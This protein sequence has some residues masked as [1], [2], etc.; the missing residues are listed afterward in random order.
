[1]IGLPFTLVVDGQSIVDALKPYFER[2]IMDNAEI[3]TALNTANA[4]LEA[5]NTKLDL[6]VEHFDKGINEVIVAISN[7]TNVPQE[8]VDAVNRLQ[9]NVAAASA[10]VDI[11]EG[12]AQTLD[13]LNVDTPPAA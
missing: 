11:A 2:L 7:S 6:V 9:T 13:D 5:S 3:L 12:R 10:K 1:M 8:V 4:A